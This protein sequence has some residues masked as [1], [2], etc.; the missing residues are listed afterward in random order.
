MSI[1][2]KVATPAVIIIIPQKRN[3]ILETLFGSLESECMN[4]RN[5]QHIKYSK[6]S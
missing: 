3:E 5:N 4:K 1:T 2:L 6:R